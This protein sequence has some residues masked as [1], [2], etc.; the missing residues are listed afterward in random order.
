VEDSG[1]ELIIMDSTNRPKLNS[2]TAGTDAIDTNK[3]KVI[4]VNAN[5]VDGDLDYWSTFD[6]TER[7]ERNEVESGMLAIEEEQINVKEWFESHSHNRVN[8]DY[9]PSVDISKTIILAEIRPGM[10][11]VLDGNH[12]IEETYRENDF[13]IYSYKLKGEQ[14]LPYFT[15]KGRYQSFVDYWHVKL[16]ESGWQRKQLRIRNNDMKVKKSGKHTR[17][18]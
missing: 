15:S 6:N 17:F 14:L 4:T 12:R 18:F 7:L 8:E 9:L 1:A 13:F 16:T 3:I 2:T 10:F 11:S 5:P